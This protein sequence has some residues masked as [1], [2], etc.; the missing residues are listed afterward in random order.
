MKRGP[1]YLDTASLSRERATAMVNL[2]S[3]RYGIAPPALIWAPKSPRTFYESASHSIQI[4]RRHGRAWHA[5][6]SVLHEMAHAVLSF[7]GVTH[8]HDAVF[9]GVLTRI[10]LLWHGSEEA[11]DWDH[12][13][14]TVK[15][16]R[17]REWKNK[18]KSEAGRERRLAR[19]RRVD[20]R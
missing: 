6:D 17:D 4:G 8:R 9:T 2:L 5:E 16:E 19:S 7:N 18:K 11:Y 14:K 20:S 15:Q 3:Y 12:E 10:S 1:A 13:Y